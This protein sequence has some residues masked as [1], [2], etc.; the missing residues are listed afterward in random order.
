M[1]Q[2]DRS[3]GRITDVM[4]ETVFHSDATAGLLVGAAIREQLWQIG[5]LCFSRSYVAR[6]HGDEAARLFS[7]VRAASLAF[8]E[9]L[10]ALQVDEEKIRTLILLSL[11][12]QGCNSPRL[13]GHVEHIHGAEAAALRHRLAA[14]AR[15][16][17][18]VLPAMEIRDAVLAPV[19]EHW[20]LEGP[21]EAR[22]GTD[23]PNAKWADPFG[24][25][26]TAQKLMAVIREKG[27][28]PD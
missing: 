25:F 1:A 8:A 10:R 15:T 18:R 24:D 3:A 11:L 6:A 7:D 9:S 4:L 28:A 19:L 5:Y 20:G 23:D 14:A 16:L 12:P 26:G 17:L 13:H 21:R 2:D 27:L 22:S